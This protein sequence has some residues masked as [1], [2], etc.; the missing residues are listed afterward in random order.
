[1]LASILAIVLT[2]ADCATLTRR[3]TQEIPV[4]SSPAGAAVIV[5]GV[6]QGVTPV[7]LKLHRKLKGQT[8]RI[9][10]PGYNP[11]EIRLVRR[12]SAGPFLGNLLL[13]LIPGILPAGAWSV[14][15]D[16]QGAEMVWFFSAAAF[17]ALFTAG[18]AGGA[19]Y[20][21]APSVLVIT[22]TKSD[23]TPRVDTL[24]VGAD[25]LRNVVWIRVHKE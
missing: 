24:P 16:G 3:T 18:D 13:G 14:A 20:E 5:N 4:T 2:A 6:R 21:L 7:E 23:G 19:G 25:G 15:H 1:M 17:G 12:I 10:S 11:V 8:I 9:E 22:M